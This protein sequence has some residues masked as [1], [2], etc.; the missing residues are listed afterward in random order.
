MKITREQSVSEKKTKAKAIKQTQTPLILCGP[1][2]EAEC[3]QYQ[4][5][6]HHHQH[7]TTKLSSIFY[8][9]SKKISIF[10][11]LKRKKNELNPSRPRRPW[12]ERMRMRESE[13]ARLEE[14][15]NSL[16]CKRQP[17]TNTDRHRE[18]VPREQ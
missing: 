1:Q 18:A 13:V 4:Y 7:T 5:N 3:H 11:F 8:F 14:R 6:H 17:Y 10:V 16:S 12:N 15:K 9:A 2:T